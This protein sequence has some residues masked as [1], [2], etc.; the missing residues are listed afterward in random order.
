MLLGVGVGAV[1]VSGCASTVGQVRG[2]DGEMW[3]SISCHRSQANC[4]ERAGEECPYGYVAGA[5][6]GHEGAI[7]SHTQYSSIVTPVYNGTLMVK[8]KAPPAPATAK[9]NDQ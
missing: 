8:C 1:L 7:V 5:E 3:L 6:D 9:A 4:Y 2:P